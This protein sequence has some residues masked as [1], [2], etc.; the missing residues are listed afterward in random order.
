MYFMSVVGGLKK[1]KG[2][3]RGN[4]SFANLCVKLQRCFVVTY[5]VQN[6]TRFLERLQRLGMYRLFLCMVA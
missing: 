4:H 6:H 3:N 2:R 5:C 1:T